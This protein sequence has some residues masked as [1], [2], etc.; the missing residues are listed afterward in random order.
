MDSN[1]TDMITYQEFERY[2]NDIKEYNDLISELNDVCIKHNRNFE[3]LF[4]DSLLCDVISLLEQLTN[5]KSQWISY[6]I[7]ELNFGTS[8]QQG[9]VLQDKQDVPLKTIK[10]L[11]NIITQKG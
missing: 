11:W 10:D 8:Y 6:W 9:M 3:C 2:I 5:D 1:D 7:F 4:A